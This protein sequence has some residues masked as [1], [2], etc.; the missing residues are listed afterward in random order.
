MFP[1]IISENRVRSGEIVLQLHGHLLD[2]LAKRFGSRT[3][4]RARDGLE[5]ML[6][7]VLKGMSRLLGQIPD[8]VVQVVQGG[9]NRWLNLC[10]RLPCQLGA[11]L[12]HRPC[13]D[14]IGQGC[15]PPVR[16]DTEPFGRIRRVILDALANFLG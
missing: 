6:G 13:H 14:F 2:F 9:S 7:V 4:D 3:Q 1:G 16:V 10:L 15:Q 12:L 11:E 8:L 5:L